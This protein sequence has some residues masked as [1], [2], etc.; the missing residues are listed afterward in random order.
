MV[1]SYSEIGCFSSFPI[2]VNFFA[3]ATCL[4]SSISRYLGSSHFLGFH[5][6]FSLPWRLCLVAEPNSLAFA[7]AEEPRF[8]AATLAVAAPSENFII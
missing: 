1:E 2:F 4:E 7:E 3:P 6:V 8:E 5:I